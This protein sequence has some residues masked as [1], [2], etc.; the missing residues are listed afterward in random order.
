MELSLR[1]DLKSLWH[2]AKTLSHETHYKIVDASAGGSCKM[3]KLMNR[4]ARLRSV[5]GTIWHFTDPP[6]EEMKQ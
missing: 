5:L 1:Q 4:L 2:E 6:H 3:S